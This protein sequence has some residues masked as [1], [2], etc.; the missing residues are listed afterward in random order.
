M[1]VIITDTRVVISESD[2]T[3]GWTASDGVTVFTSAPTPVEASGSL[4][5]QVS[6]SL[7]SA[8]VTITSADLSDTLVY[9]WLLPGGVLDD[10]IGT[11]SGDAGIQIYLG[12]GTNDRGY[13]VGGSNEAAFRHNDGPVLWQCFALD[14]SNLP[15]TFTN[16]VGAGAPT[17]TTITRIGNAF[18]TLVKSVG[19]VENCF[20]DILF[21]GNGGIIITGGG[22]GTE[23]KFSEIALRDRSETDHPGQNV[24]SA[25][26]AAYGICRELGTSSFGLQGALTFGDAAGTGSVDF[27]DGGESVL[28]ED[29]NF[30]TNKYG[31]TVTGNGTGTTSVIWGTRDGIGLGS[32][33]IAFTCPTGIGA[34]FTATS[35]N[36][37]TL[38]I[39]GC[40]F[41]NF[42]QG[43]TFTTDGTA[44]PNHEI[45]ASNFDGCSQITIGTTEFKNNDISGTTS[46]GTAEAAAL[47]S[48]TTNIADLTFTSGGTGHAIEIADSANSPFTFDGYVFNGYAGTDGGTGNEVI[49]NTS[50]NAITI[51]ITGGLG[52]PSVDT[53]N[54]TG[55]VTIVNNVSN[56]VTVLDAATNPIVGAVVAVYNSATDLVLVNDETDGN[57]EVTFSSGASIPVYV[58]VRKSTSG[59][60]RYI[61][62]ETVG[63]TGSSGLSVTVTLIVDEIASA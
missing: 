62:V 2:A 25:T 52:F 14:T 53:T 51:N 37:N 45:F 5:Q 41:L 15:T 4:G 50:G 60:T 8:Y 24:A 11:S 58:R 38:G 61:P 43:F 7:E 63:N 47:I 20:M 56:T 26:G 59:S 49:V 22:A 55:T 54:S 17:L 16:F 18:R 6:N 27:E 21:Y 39:Y 42:D 1:A 29:R 13:A 33:G 40:T 23:G 12:D 28:F 36:I 9:C 10:N 32:G 3:T 30:G 31:L 44:G 35:A 57:G 19:G 34:F 48:S 46:T